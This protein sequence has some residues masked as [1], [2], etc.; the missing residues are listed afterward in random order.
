MSLA[1]PE[2]SRSHVTAE[3][4]HTVRI[5]DRT[6]LE[7]VV[8]WHREAFPAGFYAQLGPRFMDRWFRF[9]LD[10]PASVSLVACDSAG[11]VVGYLL[12]TLD[13]A[14]YGSRALTED[15]Q[16]FARGA[17]ALTVRPALGIE[18]SRRR[19]RAYA[20][21]VARR[22][23]RG[24][25]PRR[26]GAGDGELVYICVESDH[27]RQGA[28]AALLDAFTGEALRSGTRRLHLVTEADNVGAQ[29]FYVR[30]GWHVMD[31]TSQ[32]LDGRTLVRMQRVLDDETACAD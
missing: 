1:T 4:H 20:G 14:E 7:A 31:D 18:F 6:D 12:G 22:L 21:R 10:S 17:A 13:D 28:G 15:A 26:D 3:A 19:A 23:K 29:R 8:A 25:T 27:R 32:A 11:S 9:H 30:H 5:M 16:L 24:S 2:A